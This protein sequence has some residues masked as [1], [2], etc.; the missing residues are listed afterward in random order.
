MHHPSPAWYAYARMSWP[1]RTHSLPDGRQLR[2]TYEGEPVGW[3]VHLVGDEYRPVG[4]RGIH[5][6]LEDLL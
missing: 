6:A 4:A 3:V 1:E 5:D 2:T